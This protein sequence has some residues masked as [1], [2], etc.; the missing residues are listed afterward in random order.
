MPKT[1]KRSRAAANS[2]PA[3]TGD[4][5]NVLLR[6]L[7]T[8]FYNG[9][10]ELISTDCFSLVSDLRSCSSISRSHSSWLY[11]KPLPLEAGSAADSQLNAFF[12]S[13]VLALTKEK[14]HN[15]FFQRYS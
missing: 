14:G 15:F 13:L 5:A 6:L 3:D 8:E 12:L 1:R 9:F 7:P 10:S 2:S 4:V 11:K